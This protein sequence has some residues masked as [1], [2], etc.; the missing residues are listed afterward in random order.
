MESLKKEAVVLK[1][2]NHKNIVKF[3]DVHYKIDG[4]YLFLEY[5]SMV[6]LN[7]IYALF[8]SAGNVFHRS[9]V[10]IPSPHHPLN[11]PIP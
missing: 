1:E 11:I 5:V 7:F 2:L 8:Y 4:V 3:Y 6:N 9:P 10:P